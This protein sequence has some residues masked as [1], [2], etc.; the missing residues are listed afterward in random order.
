MTWVKIDDKFYDNP[1]NR[2]LGPAGR[3]LFIA[4]L[5]YCAKGLTD[6]VIPKCDL[7]LLLAQA[8]A[9]K[10]T[11]E[12]LLEAGRWLDL[13]DRF[14]VVEYLTY[15][16]SKERVLAERERARKKKQ[17]Q[18][19]EADDDP[20]EEQDDPVPPDVP[21][22]VPPGTP[23]RDTPLG[24]PMPPS[25]PVPCSASPPGLVTVNGDREAAFAAFWNAYPKRVAKATARTAFGKALKRTTADVLI[26]GAQSYADDPSRDPDYTKHPATWLNGDCWEDERTR[27][28]RRSKQTA[29]AARLVER[30]AGP[31]QTRELHA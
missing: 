28:R 15:Q 7:P 5:T 27:E 30:H 22:V 25:R 19:A 29:A 4:G 3:D 9:K 13:G 14:E 24:V 2:S 17:R 16:L 12:K 23:P 1:T 21:Q 20:H 6:G 11:V 10:A 31:S 26:A 18:R 8:Q